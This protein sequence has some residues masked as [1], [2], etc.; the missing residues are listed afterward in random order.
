MQG[1]FF[2]GEDI[3]RQHSIVSIDLLRL[4]A[5]RK[6]EKQKNKLYQHYKEAITFQLVQLNIVELLKKIIRETDSELQELEC[7]I[8]SDKLIHYPGPITEDYLQHF[9]QVCP[10]SCVWKLAADAQLKF[11]KNSASKQL[12]CILKQYDNEEW[13]HKDHGHSKEKRKINEKY[14]K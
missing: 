4:L 6:D 11:I 12:E 9:Y 14:E 2:R 3:M 8:L 10:P 13:Y 7:E 1:V 5:N